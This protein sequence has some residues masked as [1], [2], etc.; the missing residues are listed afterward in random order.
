MKRILLLT[1]SVA[2]ALTSCDKENSIEDLDSKSITQEKKSKELAFIDHSITPNFLDLKPGFKNLKITTLL[3]SEDILR[4]TPDFIY[5]SMADGAGLLKNE[6]GTFSL[7]NNIEA[8]YSVARITLD[9]TFK[10]VGGEYILNAI[11]TGYNAQC[12]GS[13]NT[14]EEHGFGPLYFSG[15]EWNSSTPGVYAVDPYKPASDASSSWKLESMGQWVTENAV[16]LHKNAYPNKTVVVIGDDDSNSSVPSGHFAMYVGD[17]GDLH[18][19]KVYGLSVPG[20]AEPFEKQLE[21]GVTQEVSFIEL[22]SRLLNELDAEC[23]A[24]GVMG[25]SRVEDIDWRRGSAQNNREIYF[26]VTGRKSNGHIGKG[27]TYGRIYQLIL[28]ENDP[29]KGKITCILD[30][31]KFEGKAKAFHS[32]DNVLVTEDYIYIQE[33][34]NG[35]PDIPAK[36]HYAYLY[37]YNINSKNLKVVLECDQERAAQLGY[38]STNDIWEITGMIDV[39]D[40]IGEKRAHILIT[41]NHGWVPADGSAF[42]DPDANPNVEGSIKE[43]SQLY[44]VR[45]LK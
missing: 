5:G 10:P 37:E 26:A 36:D 43:G 30:G 44:L 22:Q 11:A 41:Q 25:F 7:I 13:L 14:P 31:D 32:P 17:R 39:S 16:T 15:G 27:T 18:N 2:L 6:D 12:S 8:D 23:K 20:V 28:D 40:I 42:T 34:P 45:G 3:S 24:K 19:G 1:F 4:N 21:E 35:Y 9:Q 29:T 38:G 33:D